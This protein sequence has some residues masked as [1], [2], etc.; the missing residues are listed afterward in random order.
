MSSSGTIDDPR[1][2]LGAKQRN[3]A[4]SS[5]SLPGVSKER[6]TGKEKEERRTAKEKENREK[7]ILGK[8]RD[9]LRDWVE[10]TEEDKIQH[11]IGL[12]EKDAGELFRDVAEVKGKKRLF[13][14][15]DGTWQNAVGTIRPMSNVA[16]LA[17]SI[18]RVG[19]DSFDC[20]TLGGVPQL[21][22]YS[23]GI[24]GNSIVGIDGLVAAATGKGF[25][26]TV[27]SAYCFISNN[28]NGSS[29]RDDIILVG[30]SRGAF[31]MRC[32][33]QFISDVGLLRRSG[34]SHLG[35]FWKLWLSDEKAPSDK[36]SLRKVDPKWEQRKEELRTLF[37]P[38]RKVMIN[39][40]AEWDPVKSLIWPSL[41][42]KRRLANMT[43]TV[44]DKVENAFVAISLNE[45]RRS[46]KPVI[47]ERYKEWQN[48]RQCAFLGGHID[49]GGGSIDA[50]LSTISLFWMIA[51]IGHAC[52]ARFD[53]N[54]LSQFI[55]PERVRVAS[56]NM[57]LR[58][59][60]ETCLTTQALSEGKV[61]KSSFLWRL[62]HIFSVGVLI[63]GNRSHILKAAAQQGQTIAEGAEQ[64]VRAQEGRAQEEIAQGQ[65]EQRE[66]RQDEAEQ[67]GDD[68]ETYVGCELEIHKTVKWI[69][70]PPLSQG[71]MVDQIPKRRDN[72]GK[73]STALKGFT[74]EGGKWKLG[75][76]K[77]CLKEAKLISSEFHMVEKWM[78]V[79]E[80]TQSSLEYLRSEKR[81]EHEREDP[82]REGNPASNDSS[83]DR[84]PQE[85][86]NNTGPDEDIL[87]QVKSYPWSRW[88][89][90]VDNEDM[91]ISTSLIKYLGPLYE[92]ERAADERE[93]QLENES[94]DRSEDEPEYRLSQK[95][96]SKKGPIDFMRASRPYKR[97]IEPSEIKR[98]NYS[99]VRP[100]KA[101]EPLSIV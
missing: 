56:R 59:E 41:Q 45:N 10:L 29:E 57:W 19:G 60:R 66:G 7:A 5:H 74:H 77:Y 44:P 73:S 67:G 12:Q 72:S 2:G 30:Y 95:T 92:K 16:K 71:E 38:E 28:Y 75:G 80:K 27:L 37:F 15:C 50:G 25:T 47:W 33:A 31:A 22:Y 89:G 6:R 96:T 1:A 17:R 97:L 65:V 98:E 26:N 84:Q 35:M 100:G 62:P 76:D 70:E 32:L 86:E 20:G 63:D 36:N 18:Y 64:N 48:V 39:V 40:L 58:R 42:G 24:G 91:N 34:L 81:K 90:A 51:S 88:R 9:S 3:A 8:M 14:C 23:S 83:A 69:L 93:D 43:K 49:I 68:Q 78:K 55:L 21:A 11:E 61:T 85:E 53:T 46:F 13:V 52:D 4:R 87:N 54:V 79:A 82:E 94:E 101:V 99:Y